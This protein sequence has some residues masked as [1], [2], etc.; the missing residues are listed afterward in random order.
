MILN[1][2]PS[3]QNNKCQAINYDDSIDYTVSEE[4]EYKLSSQRI[5]VKTCEDVLEPNLSF[6][7]WIM[8]L[9]MPFNNSIIMNVING[10]ILG[11]FVSRV[12]FFGI[13]YPLVKKPSRFCKKDNPGECKFK[14]ISYSISDQK[15]LNDLDDIKKLS[16]KLQNRINTNSWTIIGIAIIIISVVFLIMLI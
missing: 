4:N 14:G 1:K 9:L 7:A 2:Y 5:I 11:Y 12:S 10:L 15:N 6:F 8:L 16:S 13:Q 3:R